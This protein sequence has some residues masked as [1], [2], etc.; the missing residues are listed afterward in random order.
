M[1]EEPRHDIGHGIEPPPRQPDER[2]PGDI[3]FCARC[4]GAVDREAYFAG[5]FYCPTCVEHA[6]D[7]PWRT[8]HGGIAP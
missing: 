3:R 7:F 4:L 1:S 6:D 5:D 2:L 8:T